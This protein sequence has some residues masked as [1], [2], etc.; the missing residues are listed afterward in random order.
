MIIHHVSIY[1]SAKFQRKI[2]ANYKLHFCT[3]K[4]LQNLFIAKNGN[5]TILMRKKYIYIN[6][7]IIHHGSICYSDAYL[8]ISRQLYI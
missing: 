4:K 5:F 8:S 3:N 2:K 1:Y 6:K 7:I